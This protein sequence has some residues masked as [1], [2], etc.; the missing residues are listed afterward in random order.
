MSVLPIYVTSIL[1]EVLLFFPFF[2][3]A[4]SGKFFIYSFK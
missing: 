1:I 3:I 4:L 2:L